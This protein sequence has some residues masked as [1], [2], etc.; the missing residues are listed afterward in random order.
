ML[1]SGQ[2]HGV[3][4]FVFGLEKTSKLT[5]TNAYQNSEWFG[6][7][8]RILRKEEEA[9][10][11]KF[12]KTFWFHVDYKIGY[13]WIHQGRDTYLPCILKAKV[14]HILKSTYDGDEHWGKKGTLAKL[15]SYIYWP[16]QSEDISQYIE[17]YIQCARHKPILRSQP[18]Y[19]VYIIHPLELLGMDWISLLLVTK[20]EMIYIF[21]I[22]CYFSRYSFTYVNPTTNSE[23]II[24]LWKILFIR[25]HKLLAIYYDR[26][27]YFDT[28]ETKTFLHDE[29]VNLS[30]N[31]LGA[32]KSMGIIKVGNRIVQGVLKKSTSKSDE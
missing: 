13:F 32:F 23:D 24:R 1:E 18:L 29:R 15:R 30:F 6:R 28:E 4:V 22:I 20:S 27:Q 7:I 19:P 14:R 31:A 8:Y 5:W 17:N 25:Y 9:Q 16:N 10:P 11:K 21:H 3:D 2:F 12:Q 26:G